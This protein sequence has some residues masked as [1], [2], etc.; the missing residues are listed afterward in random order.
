MSAVD[1]SAGTQLRRA[2][3]FEAA[4]ATSVRST[5][6]ALLAFV[7]IMLA[8]AAVFAALTATGAAPPSDPVLLSLQGVF[9]GQVALGLL[10][11][12]VVTSEYGSGLVR[13]SLAAVPAR[14]VLLAAKA[15]VV[16]GLTA[17]VATATSLAAFLLAQAVLA[18]DG[19]DV[20]LTGPGVLRAVVG[21]GAYLALVAV[22]GVGLG[23]LVRSTAAA[24]V[25][26]TG[27][28]FL[29]PVLVQ[30]LPASWREVVLPWLP[31]QA[32]QAVLQ[33]APGDLFLGPWTGLAVLAGY[34]LAVL[35]AGGVR[36]ARSDA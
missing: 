31:S 24:V 28:L 26:L 22:L 32:G 9:M 3:R 7:A 12:L 29:L 21:C 6:W 17:V 23:A 30:L 33:P 13:V 1:V 27:G 15:L 25:L 10:G 5:L 8:L 19:L 20:A 34:A 14:V 36:L 18:S 16:L 2:V 4:K 11:A 35:V